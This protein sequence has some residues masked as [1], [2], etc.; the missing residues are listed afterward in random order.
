VAICA[1]RWRGKEILVSAVA[2]GGDL[3]PTQQYPYSQLSPV[4]AT[5]VRRTTRPVFD[6]LE[7]IDERQ[8]LPRWSEYISQNSMNDHSL[9][10]RPPHHSAAIVAHILRADTSTNPM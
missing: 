9:R 2:V 5:A 3:P 1:S 10:W 4:L 8:P 6:S 7:Q